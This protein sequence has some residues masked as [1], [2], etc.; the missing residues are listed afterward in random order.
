MIT[1]E[2]D[3]IYRVCF[4]ENICQPDSM[5]IN[6]YDLNQLYS[7]H[8]LIFLEV[9]TILSEF[10]FFILLVSVSTTKEFL[11]QKLEKRILKI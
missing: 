11:I 10:V 9:S 8:S 6:Y 2:Y 4:R 3:N 1:E 5:M 7:S